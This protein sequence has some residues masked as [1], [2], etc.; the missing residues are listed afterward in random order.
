MS[1][2]HLPEI[3]N[4]HLASLAGDPYSLATYDRDFLQSLSAPNLVSTLVSKLII[5]TF[6]VCFEWIIEWNFTVK[7]QL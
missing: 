5:E 6:Q 4:H 1:I 3:V 2:I 7:A